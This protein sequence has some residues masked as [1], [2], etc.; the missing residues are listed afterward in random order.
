VV[1]AEQGRLVGVIE[2]GDVARADIEEADERYRQSQGIVGGEEL[3]ACRCCC[4]RGAGS[5]G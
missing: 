4:A 5:R 2:A 1:V 3:G